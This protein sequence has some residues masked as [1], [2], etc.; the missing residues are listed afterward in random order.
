M[1]NA[2]IKRF[3][4]LPKKKDLLDSLSDLGIRG[5][6]SLELFPFSSSCPTYELRLNKS[7]KG[8]KRLVLRFAVQNQPVHTFFQKTTIGKEILAYSYLEE[9]G[10]KIPQIINVGDLGKVRITN[11][12]KR[13]DLKYFIMTYVDGQAF[14]HPFK[15]AD[16]EK[17]IELLRKLLTIYARIH[18]VKKY[19]FGGLEKDNPNEPRF[20]CLYDYW[21]WLREGKEKILRAIN[22]SESLD[23]LRVYRES[24]KEVSY[25]LK[26]VS[27]E[28]DIKHSSLVI[29][30]LCAGNV[31]VDETSNLTVIDPPCAVFSNHLMEFCTL[32][33]SQEGVLKKTIRGKIGF[34]VIFDIYREVGGDVPKKEVRDLL[35]HIF[36][37]NHF[38]SAYIYFKTHI[39]IEKQIKASAF[40]RMIGNFVKSPLGHWID[41]TIDAFK[42]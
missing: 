42:K 16:E 31:L 39:N 11:N 34:E 20:N 32:I 10:I 22:D 33:F 29:Y 13:I 3:Q 6:Q 23:V 25:V 41:G 27:N 37:V 17:R 21:S 14:C 24:N 1:K 15:S 2:R 18:S 9:I 5:V 4:L 19:I 30:D 38:V 28:E 35:L 26:S 8:H 36:L 7:F 40:G 12:S